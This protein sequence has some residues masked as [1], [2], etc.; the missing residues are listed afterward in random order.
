M[1]GYSG[2]VHLATQMPNDTPMDLWSF[3]TNLPR[4]TSS[5]MPMSTGDNSPG[6]QIQTSEHTSHLVCQKMQAAGVCCMT[7]SP[8]GLCVF[9]SND[10][11]ILLLLQE[12]VQLSMTSRKP[13]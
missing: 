1:S 7:L 8:F 3:E 10:S 2:A 11:H 13:L 4:E 9:C 5:G 12:A 6:N